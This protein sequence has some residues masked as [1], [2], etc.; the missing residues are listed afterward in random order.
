[1]G[2]LVFGL[3]LVA[4]MLVVRSVPALAEGCPH[5]PQCTGCGCAGGPGYRGPDGQCVGFR[6]LTS[7]CGTPP[8]TR[9]TFENAPGTGANAEC[10]TRPRAGDGGSP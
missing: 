8:T 7:K 5:R 1:V 9:C 4:V 2:R 6:Q 3:L 10:A